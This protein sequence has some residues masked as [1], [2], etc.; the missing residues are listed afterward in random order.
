MK[1]L[2]PAR[3]FAKVKLPPGYLSASVVQKVDLKSLG[4]LQAHK[5]NAALFESVLNYAR[6]G[7][8]FV[9]HVVFV[10]TKETI[11][12]LESIIHPGSS[13]QLQNEVVD[14]LLDALPREQR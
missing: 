2:K 5:A 4:S 14:A 9:Q 10:G 3:S 13:P 11:R 8:I 12:D 1:K 6:S 7:A